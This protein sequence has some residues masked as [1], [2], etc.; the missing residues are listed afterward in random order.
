MDLHLGVPCGISGVDGRGPALGDAGHGLLQG[1]QG[2]GF[3]T[4]RGAHQHQPVAQDSHLIQLDTLLDE[5]IHRLQDA[6]LEGGQQV[7][8]QHPVVR[9]RQHHPREQVRNDTLEED[10]VLL[11]EL[12][13]VAV[14]QGSQQ[15]QV[16]VPVAV[17]TLHQPGRANHGID[18]AHPVVVVVLARQL[19]RGE[20]ERGHHL[21]RQAT[22]LHVPK[23]EQPN[24]PNQGVVGYHACHRAEKHFQ[25]V[26]QLRTAGVARVHGNEDGVGR[27]NQ[28]VTALKLNSVIFGDGCLLDIVHLLSHNG[29]HLDVDAVE[30]VEAR[31]GTSHGQPLEEFG[32]GPEI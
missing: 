32:H 27:I 5:H 20:T 10:D 14:P 28:D 29:Q 2:G 8:H 30:L 31:P 18:S 13:Q 25:V 3:A 16:L 22:R 4:P 21:L 23:G 26:R 19:L 15:Q 24:L 6:I 17:L 12:R 1:A 11:Q 7:I 9:V